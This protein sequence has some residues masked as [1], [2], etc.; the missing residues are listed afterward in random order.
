M[1]GIASYPVMPRGRLVEDTDELLVLEPGTEVLA[2]KGCHNAAET[3][4]VCDLGHDPYV[5]ERRHASNHKGDNYPSSHFCYDG[6]Q[7]AYTCPAGELL[8]SSGTMYQRKGSTHRFQ[9]YRAS[10]KVCGRCPLRGQ[11]I[12]PPALGKNAA[13]SLHPAQHPAAAPKNQ[14]QP[15]LRI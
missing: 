13:R 1:R 3:Q 4:R 2:D 10:R 5:A 15:R 8:L 12:T 6:E 14:K 7:D 9:A 11:G